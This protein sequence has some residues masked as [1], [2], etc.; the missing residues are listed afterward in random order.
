MT[1]LKHPKIA[2][3]TLLFFVSSF[4]RAVPIGI[5]DSGVDLNHHDLVN[6]VWTNS[7]LT[8]GYPDDK[9]GWNFTENNNHLIDYSYLGRFSRDVP[10]Y[11]EIQMKVLEGKATNDDY[12]WI[13]E[14]KKDQ[15]FIRDLMLF[16]NFVHGTHVAGISSKITGHAEIMAAKII[17]TEVIISSVT[18]FE[19]SILSFSSIFNSLKG[20]IIDYFMNFSLNYLAGQQT[21]LLTRVG[22]YIDNTKM[23]IVNCSFGI[24]Q[25]QA[26]MIV[27]IIARQLFN[28]DLTEAEA[29]KYGR[30]FM[31]R[32]LVKGSGFV[33]SAKNTLFVMAAGNDGLD[34]DLFQTY[35]GSL[36]FDNT[37]T[38]AA[39]RGYERLASFS[40][41][42]AS[43]VEVA[44]P[45]VGIRS[46]IPGDEYLRLSGTSQAA[47][48]VTRVAGRILDTN[49]ILNLSDVKKI[50]MLTVDKKLFLEGKVKSGGIVNEDRALRAATYSLN[51]DV[52]SAIQKARVDIEDVRHEQSI[53]ELSSINRTESEVI[54]ADGEP[55]AL[56]SPFVLF[57]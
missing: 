9:H 30:Y 21:Q 43:Q 42:G 1:T 56:P 45:G 3:S 51:G 25:D 29:E 12:R 2:F 17:P 36:K 14:K 27:G 20:F 33:N 10:K 16:G 52:E 46:A 19:A 40:N 18:A 4:S 6:K 49:P 23:R 38:V 31:H 11:F 44:A 15:T 13:Q 7:G 26:K 39:T 55:I 54:S 57:Q 41:Y 32:I 50:L 53:Y 28:K 35:P 37:I 34:N 48:F 5:I 47:P 24:S 22:R 8:E